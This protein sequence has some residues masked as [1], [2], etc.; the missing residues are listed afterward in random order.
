[1]KNYQEGLINSMQALALSQLQNIFKNK[2]NNSDEK[3]GTSGSFKNLNTISSNK[4]N[5]IDVSLSYYNLGVQQEY[6]RRKNDCEI[7]YTLS[8]KYCDTENVKLKTKL[9][10]GTIEIAKTTSSTKFSRFTNGEKKNE[11][12]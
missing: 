5:D 2:G 7:S 11:I 6:M 9:N 8:K 1:M 3:G 10:L 12:K 4:P